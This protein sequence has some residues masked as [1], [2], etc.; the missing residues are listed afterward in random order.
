ML[1]PYKS[2]VELRERP[3]ETT[4]LIFANILALAWTATLKEPA[5][6]RFFYD[7][8]FVPFDHR[9]VSYLTHMFLHAGALHLFG[10]LLFLWIFGPAVEDRLGKA[11]FLPAYLLFGVA[12]VLVHAVSA[13]GSSLDIPM[14]GASGAISGLLGA[15]MVLYPMG[16]IRH[17]FIVVVRP[18]FFTLPAWVVLGFWLGEQLLMSMLVRASS[19]AIWAHIGGFAAGVGFTL[20]WQRMGGDTAGEA[21]PSVAGP[22]RGALAAHFGPGVDA[23]AAAQ[24]LGRLAAGKPDDGFLRHSSLAAAVRAG[25]HAA[26]AQ[27]GKRL[28][29]SLSPTDTARR[30]ETRLLLAGV[31]EADESPGCLLELADGFARTHHRDLAYPLYR[32]LL[33]LYPDHPRRQ[34]MQLWVG[35][36]LLNNKRQPEEARGF[37]EAAAEGDPR[38]ALVQEARFHL[39]KMEGKKGNEPDG[40]FVPKLED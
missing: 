24:A 40:E 28:I 25:D 11:L 16:Q 8:G 9:P 18:I 19:V 32:R 4:I 1:I 33:E 12:A 2:D 35:E 14:V 39:K 30:F 6:A 20:L 22:G 21:S 27:D 26:A 36:Y 34:S 23:Q 38:N 37:L 15:F 10:N 13:S 7:Y 17:V 31:G 29:E 5:L 3:V